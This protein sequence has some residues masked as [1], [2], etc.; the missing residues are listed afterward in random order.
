MRPTTLTVG[1]LTTADDD[2]ISASQTPGAAG[3]LTIAGALASGG[4][5]TLDKPRRVLVTTV[6]NESAKTLTVYGTNWYGQSITETITGPN[7]TTGYTSYDFATVTRVAVSAAFT[8]AVKVGTNGVASSPPIF[9]DSYGIGPTALQVT[10][11]GTVNFTVQQSLDDP[12]SV[13]YTSTTWV[14]HPD[15][16]LAAATATAQGNYTYAPRVVRLLL[17]SGTGSA[18]LTVAQMGGTDR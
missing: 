7:A 17:N 14:N 13:G 12:N 9:L 8:G 15:T 4:S 5:V 1:T 3:N 2:G 16:G 11:S 10:V 18:Q 6:S